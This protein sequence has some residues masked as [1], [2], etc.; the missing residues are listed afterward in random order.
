MQPRIHLI[1]ALLSLVTTVVTGGCAQSQSAAWTSAQ[2]LAGIGPSVEATRLNPAYRYLHVTANG[3]VALLVLGEIERDAAGRPVEV[4][5]SASKEVLRLQEGRLVGMTGLPVE[6][7]AVKLPTDLPGWHQLNAPRQY[8]RQR[9]EMP[10][11]RLGLTEQ[12]TVR[13]VTAP[14]NSGLLSAP[15]AG[16]RWFEETSTP[17]SDS[18]SAPQLSAAAL[19]PSRYAVINDGAASQV[20]YGEQCLTPA[21]CLQW[22]AWPPRGTDH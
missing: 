5:L 18:E 20:L 4:W 21:L 12:V 3:K 14:T 22:Q 10:G 17:V 15:P 13:P 11:Y 6:W 9:D 7:R 2:Y 8:L 16:L 1:T 19:P